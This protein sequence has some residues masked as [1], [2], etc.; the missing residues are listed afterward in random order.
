MNRRNR[1]M[2]RMDR[3]QFL[4]RTG[5]GAAGLGAAMAG[6]GGVASA[7]KPMKPPELS[8]TLK[9]VMGYGKLKVGIN[10]GNIV[11]F[12]EG[13][14]D[15]PNDT[16]YLAPNEQVT[17]F[18]PDLARALAAAIFG[19][20]KVDK[21][22]EFVGVTSTTR[23][24]KLLSYEIDIVLRVCTN[25]LDRDVY[26]KD[27]ETGFDFGPT[28]YYDGADVLVWSDQEVPP[29][30]GKYYIAAGEGTTSI[31]ALYQ[32]I[33]EDELEDILEVVPV[34][35]STAAKKSFENRVE[36]QKVQGSDPAVYE[37]VPDG[38]DPIHGYVTDQSALIGASLTYPADATRL[39]FIKKISK[40]PLSPCIREDDPKWGDIVSWVMWALKE[41]EEQGITMSNVTPEWGRDLPELGLHKQWPYHVISTVGNF[42]EV[43]YRNF[44]KPWIE[45]IPPLQS[46]F[47]PRD[48]NEIYTR[49]G[50]Q[51]S[52][53]GIRPG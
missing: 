26:L 27:F 38:V 33:A 4:R 6:M 50:V 23:F 45:S 51:Y 1:T 47:D 22:I 48:I 9:N 36:Y 41:A 20:G 29:V 3:R 31:T 7:K 40:E 28:Y 11:S 49:G 32:K 39:F 42:K 30:N 35:D 12:I 2:G 18:E 37:P 19:K 44:Q 5:V 43:W 17:G 21:R 46:P 34:T 8:P 16:T 10:N 13:W 25:N 14:M 24:E 15:G 53:P 52:P